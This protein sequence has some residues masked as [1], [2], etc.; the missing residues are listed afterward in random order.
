MGPAGRSGRATTVATAAA[1]VRLAALYA[2]VTAVYALPTSQSTTWPR[3]TPTRNVTGTRPG[4]MRQNRMISAASPQPT[5]TRVGPWPTWTRA[6]WAS[7][8]TPNE[9]SSRTPSAGRHAGGGYRTATANAAS[10][11]A[12]I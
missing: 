2:I 5:E 10:S 12:G 3:A 6:I 9:T 1:M 8:T 4:G 7:T 11:P